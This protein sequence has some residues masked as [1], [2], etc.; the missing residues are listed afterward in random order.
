MGLWV[1]TTINKEII[2]AQTKKLYIR[3]PVVRQMLICLL[4][5][6]D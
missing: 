1:D 3:A 2:K 6:A 5:F 4:Y